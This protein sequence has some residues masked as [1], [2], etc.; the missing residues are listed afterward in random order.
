MHRVR[1]GGAHAFRRGG[2]G[3]EG[4]PALR[5]GR[6]FVPTGPDAR[7]GAH[8]RERAGPGRRNLRGV[9]RGG[10]GGSVRAGAQRQRRRESVGAGGRLRTRSDGRDQMYRR[11]LGAGAAHR[12]EPRRRQDCAQGQVQERRRGW[13]GHAPL[14]RR[15]HRRR[16]RRGG[17]GGERRRRVRDSIRGEGCGTLRFARLE[18]VQ[19]GRRRGV[20]VRRR[21]PPRSGV[22]VIVRGAAR[23]DA[24]ARRG[25]TGGCRRR[26]GRDALG[27]NAGEG[28]VRERHR[29]ETVADA[30]RRGFRTPG[31]RVQGTAGG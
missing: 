30:Q 20:S 1:R 18:R 3:L 24:H 6:Q 12:G 27:S 26:R 11:R 28:Q 31:R 2:E 16:A 8:A 14:S 7:V 10:Q 15:S 25:R 17:D 9:V 22:R 5:R 29:V 13:A 23:R 19:K 4:Q 21:R